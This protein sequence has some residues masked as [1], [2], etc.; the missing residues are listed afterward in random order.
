[1]KGSLMLLMVVVLAILAQAA[2][3]QL[4]DEV[5]SVRARPDGTY[6][7]VCRD[8]SFE[9]ASELDLKLDNLCPK[10][11]D[12]TETGIKNLQHR[13]DG[14]FDVVCD[15]SSAHIA[16]RHEVLAGQLCKTQLR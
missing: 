8:R 4:S 14:R 6:E 9:L 10:L 5:I 15:N 12:L 13:S 11:V 2:R 3:P 16:S 1:M 7:I